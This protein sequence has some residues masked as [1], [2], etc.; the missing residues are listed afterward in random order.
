MNPLM[1]IPIQQ[2][3]EIIRNV[4]STTGDVNKTSQCLNICFNTVQHALRSPNVSPREYSKKLNLIHLNYI[5]AKTIENP[6]I[7][8]DQLSRDIFSTF[9]IHVSGRTINRYRNELNLKYRQPIRSVYL[10]QS[11]ATKRQQWTSYHIFN[12]TIWTNVVFSDESMFILGRHKKW[13]WV[14]KHDITKKFYHK[15]LTIPLK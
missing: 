5:H 8:G 3:Y 12:N 10:S 4:Y 6:F 11:A 15:A 2:R 13:V 1:K 9:A 7:T 14:D